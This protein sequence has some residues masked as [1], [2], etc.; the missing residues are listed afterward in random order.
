M[1]E[2]A[3]S[4]DVVLRM[5]ALENAINAVAFA[6]PDWTQEKFDA[7]RWGVADAKGLLLAAAFG[8]APRDASKDTIGRLANA[9][10]DACTEHMDH[11]KVWSEEHGTDPLVAASRRRYLR[12]RRVFLEYMAGLKTEKGGP[13]GE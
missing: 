9:Y 1:S 12:A 4:L 8:D 3:V 6:D 2:P 5:A 11:L 10:M 13:D 7:M